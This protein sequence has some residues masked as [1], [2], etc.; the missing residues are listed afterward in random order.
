MFFMHSILIKK[1]YLPY[2]LF[3]DHMQIVTIL[4]SQLY[5]MLIV[6]HE[7]F[8]DARFIGHLVRNTCCR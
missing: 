1:K 8:S 3:K 4:V 5:I 6:F 7:C 2:R